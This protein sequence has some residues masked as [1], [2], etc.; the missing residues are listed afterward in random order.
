MVKLAWRPAFLRPLQRSEARQAQIDAETQHLA[1]YHLSL[2]SYCLRVRRSVWRLNLRIELRNI[3]K[4][5]DRASELR[6]GGGKLQV[7][8]LQI[9]HPD[10]TEW[11]Y[12]SD[13]IISYLNAHYAR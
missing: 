9:R 2:C 6:S 4:Q 1:L 11:L 7:P 3:A 10:Y 12:E 5:P 13:D 8:C